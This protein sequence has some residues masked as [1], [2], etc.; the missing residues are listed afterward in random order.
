[1]SSSSVF[2]FV[3]LEMHHCRPFLYEYS[4]STLFLSLPGDD[5]CPPFYYY[6][7]ELDFAS[8]LFASFAFS[9]Q[10]MPSAFRSVPGVFYP[11]PCLRSSD[12]LGAALSTRITATCKYVQF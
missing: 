6:H 7:D 4:S 11:G 2:I 9:E 1:M 8:S 12:L 10:K 3:S 5:V